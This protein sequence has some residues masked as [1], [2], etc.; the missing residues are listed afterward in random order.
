MCTEAD[1]ISWW[2]VLQ[3][4]LQCVLCAQCLLLRVFTACVAMR[5]AVWCSVLQC[6]AVW[7]SVVKCVAV[8]V[9][10]YVHTCPARRCAQRHQRSHL[11]YTM[12]TPRINTQISRVPHTNE[13]W[14][15]YL[16][17]HI[18]RGSSVISYI[19]SPMSHV[20][21]SHVTHHWVISHTGTSHVTKIESWEW[22]RIIRVS[23]SRTH[24]ICTYDYI[25]PRSLCFMT[26]MYICPMGWLWLVGSLK[27]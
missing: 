16:M 21:R 2:R 18:D 22:N 7:C 26:H 6:D 12:P 11:S 3:C 9:R 5:A 23:Y 8:S 20:W 13:S 19:T 24:D 4:V 25:S 14:H 15:I 17:S 1:K 10:I 27:Y